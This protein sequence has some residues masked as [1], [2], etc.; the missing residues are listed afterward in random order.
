MVKFI[1]ISLRN[2]RYFI[3]NPGYWLTWKT[4]F[5]LYE[6]SAFDLKIRY[7]PQNNFAEGNYD[8]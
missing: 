8:W 3:S 1:F 5:G 4:I 2:K 6:V 7:K